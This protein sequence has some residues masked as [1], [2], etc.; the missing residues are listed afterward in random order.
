MY[1]FIKAQGGAGERKDPD[2]RKGNT[3]RMGVHQQS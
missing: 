3:F 1:V 2:H